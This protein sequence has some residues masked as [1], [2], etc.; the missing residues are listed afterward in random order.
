MDDPKEGVNQRRAWGKG[1]WAEGGMEVEALG[2]D[3]TNRCIKIIG[4]P[5]DEGMMR[6]LGMVDCN[7]LIALIF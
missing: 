2:R 3:V 1:R 5:L 4:Y 6:G 7:S